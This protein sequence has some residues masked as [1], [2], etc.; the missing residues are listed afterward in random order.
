MML[1]FLLK[2]W[3]K[4]H[5]PIMELERPF[6]LECGKKFPD[7]FLLQNFDHPVC[8]NCRDNE[9]KHALITRTE[10]KNEYLLKDCNFDRRE[11]LLK[12]ISWK[13]PHNS[14]WGEMKLYLQLQIKSELLK[15]KE[16][17]ERKRKINQSFKSSKKKK[18]KLY[19]W[20]WEAVCSIGL[21]WVLTLTI[22]NPIL[23]YKRILISTRASLVVSKKLLTKFNDFK[24]WI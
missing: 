6:C 10:A 13:N 23:L 21:R 7:S 20:M 24:Q 22:L 14:N 8:D 4:Y 12:F 9:D 2:I 5:P 15:K 17:R 11:P 3:R 16:K 19:I 18:L 1:T